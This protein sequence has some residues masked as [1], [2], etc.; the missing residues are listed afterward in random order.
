[1]TA[2]PAST[3]TRRFETVTCSRCGGSGHYSYCQMHGT[4]CFKCGGTGKQL[5]KRGQVAAN[6]YRAHKRIKGADVTLGTFV[7][8]HGIAGLCA[9]TYFTVDTMSTRLEGNGSYLKDGVMVPSPPSLVLEGNNKNGVRMGLQTQ[10]DADVD[11]L[12][13]KRA[14]RELLTKAYD[15]QDTLTKAGTPRKGG[16]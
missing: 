6:W 5:T 1:M 16:K 14:A 3:E 15:Y 2:L 9:T 8:M 13:T 12:L 11:I 7:V 4:T 10:A